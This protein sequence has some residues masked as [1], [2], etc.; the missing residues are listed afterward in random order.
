MKKALIGLGA[1]A[2]ALAFSG[3]ASAPLFEYNIAFP[4][5]S[6]GAGDIS[7]FYTA[8]DSVNETLSLNFTVQ[9][10]GTNP[11]ADSFWIATSPGPNPKGQLQELALV[12]GDTTSGDVWVYE[13]NGFN[14]NT[15]FANPGNLLAYFDNALSTVNTT[16]GRTI[17]FDALDMSAVQSFYTDPDWTGVA[18][19]EDIGIWFHP[20]FTAGS[21]IGD[22]G[23]IEAYEIV[24]QSW[25]DTAN[26]TTDVPEPAPLALIAF[27]SAGLI[28]LRRRQRKAA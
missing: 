11:L 21:I 25:Y 5:G 15:S 19:G 18:F 6:E 12:Y 3:S 23:G 28:A 8:Y 1:L 13:Y 17:S 10:A 4:G 27:A 7:S 24:S 16:S 14:G 9:P 22:A 26:R 20:S 2:G